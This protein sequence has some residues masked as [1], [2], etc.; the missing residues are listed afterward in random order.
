MIHWFNKYRT[1]VG[2]EHVQERPLVQLSTSHTHKYVHDGVF[3]VSNS[4]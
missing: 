2:M 1:R 4:V 3:I